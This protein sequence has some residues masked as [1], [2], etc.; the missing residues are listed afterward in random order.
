MTRT[1]RLLFALFVFTG[2]ALSGTLI[3]P[4]GVDWNLGES[5]WLNI[6]G[7][8]QDLYFAGPIFIT[9]TQDGQQ[10][11]RDTMCADLFTDIYIGVT[12]DTAVVDPADAPGTDLGQASWLI[13]NALLPAQGPAYTSALPDSDWVESP[14][15]GAG[16]Q[17]AIWDLTADGGDGFFSGS[18][19]ASTISGEVT[20][21]A[22]LA[23]AETYEALSA[24]MTT[25]DAYVYENTAQGT[26]ALAQMLV[27]PMFSDGGP[28][29]TPSDPPPVPEPA[30]YISAGIALIGL[31]W[32]GRRLAGQSVTSRR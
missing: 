11:D 29:P 31:G 3:E 27:G 19:Q 1:S 32:C 7:T 28:T 30:T 23:W 5:L 15:Q 18:V 16:L 6:S 4:T 20:D 8:P 10:F 24:G 26:G 12:Y 21:P 14:A 17:L 25:N 22:A 2:C 9:L 13:D